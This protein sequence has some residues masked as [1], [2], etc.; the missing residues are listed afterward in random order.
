MF[1]NV[2][3]EQFWAVIFGVITAIVGALILS[4]LAGIFEFNQSILIP[5]NQG[6]KTVAIFLSCLL[7]LREEKGFIKGVI[8]GL[9]ITLITSLIASFFGNDFWDGLVI[10]LLVFSLIGAIS[11]VIAVNVKRK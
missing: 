8:T 7:I 3:K 9:V 5:I 4:F 1:K 10:D 2:I 6:I 11:G